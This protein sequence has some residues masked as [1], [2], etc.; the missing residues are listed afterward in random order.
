MQWA[1]HLPVPW[2]LRQH[3]AGRKWPAVD[4]HVERVCRLRFGEALLTMVGTVLWWWI[5]VPNVLVAAAAWLCVHHSER[6]RRR[7]EELVRQMW[8]GLK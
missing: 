1:R 6:M 3:R 2:M 5:M 7:R 8:G 4:P